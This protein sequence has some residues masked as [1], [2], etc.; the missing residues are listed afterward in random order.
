MKAVAY[1]RVSTE[2]Q[3]VD[4]FS[5]D[6]QK[7]EIEEYCK[8]NDIQL[9]QVYI[10]AGVSAYH[11]S[12]KD[13]PQG[14]FI[15]KH[16][17]EK[18]VDYV[19]SISDDRM[20]RNVEDS[21]AV[22]NF[23]SNN[24]VKLIYTRQ[25]YFNN[26]DPYSSF[27]VQNVSSIMN[28]LYSMQFSVKVKKGQINK[29]KKGG[30]NG[31]A[32]YGYKLVNSHLEINEEQASVIKLIFSMYLDGQ[33]GERICNFLNDNNYKP[34]RGKYWSKTSILGMIENE[35]YTGKTIY[36]KRPQQ[37]QRYNDR[38]EWIIVEN[39]HAPIISQEDFDAAQSI[40]VKKKK[41]N[42]KNNIDR[43]LTSMAPLAGLVFCENCHA[44]YI[45]HTKKTTKREKIYYY[46]CGS[47]KR[48]GKSVC[49]SHMIPA[50][51]LE[52]FVLYRLR[53]ILTSDMYKDQFE[54]QLTRELEIL[55]S[56]KKD[57]SRIKK[58]IGKLTTQK[59]KM[60]G[61]MLEEKDDNLINVYKE[62]LQDII[63]QL[64]LQNEQLELYQSIDISEE[65]KAIRKQFK[66][67][68]SDIT[69]KDFQELS[70]EQ[71]KVFFN[72]IIDHITIKE[73]KLF[74]EPI[75]YLVITIHLKLDGYAPKY[76]LDYLKNLNTGSEEKGNKKT[77][78]SF[79][80][81]Q[82]SNGGGEG[83]IRTLAPVSRPTP[84]AG[85]PLRPA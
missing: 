69:Y 76:T 32:P 36:N 47:R 22:N 49:D 75:I 53:E 25:Q 85:A 55:E 40:R 79:F 37:G 10:D 73:T 19:I 21:I 52:K 64:S 28:Q 83:G 65:E 20:F 3:V 78:D 33:G 59:D 45:S 66:L 34:P 31:V 77:T 42:G 57:I 72:Y 24:G 5:L 1:C 18:D 50:E 12:L 74:N 29:V 70:R 60:L 41:Q 80:K 11:N 13:R 27:L 7:K 56:K 84:L 23:A 8:N 2:E 82:L 63:S 30:W 44:L 6:T 26:L 4:G 16:I 58:D 81:N 54:Q 68:H 14:K 38:S 48:H 35:V 43:T 61:F 46:A 62:K 67:S 15:V 17:A 51:L 39:T 71:L 9:L